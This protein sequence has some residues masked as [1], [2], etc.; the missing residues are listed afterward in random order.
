MRLLISHMYNNVLSRAAGRF[1]TYSPDL[2]LVPG[3]TFIKKFEYNCH[4]KY[5]SQIQE[6][7]TEPL[8]KRINVS[9]VFNNLSKLPPSPSSTDNKVSFE[10]VV[11]SSNAEHF[12]LACKELEVRM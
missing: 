2:P 5:K 6:H 4:H 10:I 11:Q 7:I 1:T 3:V 9:F 8:Q 12:S